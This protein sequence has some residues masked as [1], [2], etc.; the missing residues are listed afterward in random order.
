MKICC[1]GAGFVGGPTMAVIALKAPDIQVT[2]V[3]MDAARIAAWNSDRLPIYEPGLDEVVK[4][5]RG[6]NL[7]FSTD[8]T[9]GIKAADIIFVAVNTPTKTYGLGAGRAADLRYIES[10]A[11][12]IGDVAE[13]LSTRSTIPWR[14]NESPCWVSPSKRTPTTHG[15][16]RRS[17]CAATGWPSR[18]T[19][20]FTIRACRPR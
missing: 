12:T 10:V 13:R 4:Q 9:G 18:P 1:I 5:A 14:T 8:V 7:H 6:R 2:V 20:R 19:S 17:R 15:S 11:R 3:D 16:R